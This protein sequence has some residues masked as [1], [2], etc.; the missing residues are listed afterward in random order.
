MANLQVILVATSA[1]LL[2][3]AVLPAAS[4]DVTV[5]DI[6]TPEFFNGIKNQ[7]PNSCVGKGFYTLDAFLRA[8]HSYPNFGNRRSL[9][10]SKREIAAFFAHVTHETGNMCYIEETNRGTYCDP[11]QFPC[12]PGKRYYGRGALQLRWNYNYAKSGRES[13]FDGVNDPDAVARDPVLAWRSALWFWVT[14]VGPVLPQGF[15]ATIRKI[16]G[17]ECD[18]GNSAA[19]RERVGYYN[20]YC[21]KFGIPLQTNAGC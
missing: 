17:K 15:G 20:S 6:V 10:G 21:R 4:A 9:P 3:A 1:I 18:G 12:A 8:V 16:N 19:V 7:A 14:N 11:T 5:A 13:N 2:A